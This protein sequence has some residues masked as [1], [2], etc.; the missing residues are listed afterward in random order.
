MGGVADFD[1]DGAVDATK[2]LD[3]ANDTVS[4]LSCG[5]QGRLLTLKN[6]WFDGNNPRDIHVADLNGDGHPDF[7]AQGGL[8]ASTSV[9]IGN[10][11]GDVSAGG[12]L[13]GSKPHWIRRCARR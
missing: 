8:S 3:V 2:S 12:Y 6:T 7:V 9:Y 13:H 4:F 1:G 5:N 11:N 10:G